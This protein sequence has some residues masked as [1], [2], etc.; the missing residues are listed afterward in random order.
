VLGFV[1]GTCLDFFTVPTS[2][3]AA[4][5]AKPLIL[6][7]FAELAHRLHYFRPKLG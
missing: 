2:S 5:F 7:A 1:F 3:G 4:N 6:N